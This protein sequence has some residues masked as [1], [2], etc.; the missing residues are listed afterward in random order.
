MNLDHCLEMLEPPRRII[1]IGAYVGD[2]PDDPL[3]RFLTQRCNEDD[4]AIVVEPLFE[5][6]LRL[7]CAYAYSPWVLP[8]NNAVASTAGKMQMYRVR[9]DANTRGL[10]PTW[11]DELSS[12]R[13]E[14]FTDL[15]DR[16]ER[17]PHIKQFLLENIEVV[18]VEAITFADLYALT[19]NKWLDLLVIDA[20]GSDYEIIQGID[21]EHVKPR[22]IYY[23][24]CLLGDDATRC[25]HYLRQNGYAL[26]VF[27]TDTLAMQE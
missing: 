12:L 15:W 17:N 25:S 10:F 19:G 27:D 3:Y 9:R 2:S 24:H 1:Q 4:C 14:R 26:T 8:V 16:H 18:E 7:A 11:V 23:E 20:E 21:F 22:F 13:H 5:N 6:C